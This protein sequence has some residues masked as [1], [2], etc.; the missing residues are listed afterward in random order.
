[1]LAADVLAK[2]ARALMSYVVNTTLGTPVSAP[3]QATVTPVAMTSIFPGAILI[4]GYGAQDQEPVTVSSTTATT[5]TAT[6]ANAHAPSEVVYGPTFPEGYPDKQLFTQAEMLAYATDA[7]NDLLLRT[8]MMVNVA[9]APVEST[10]SLYPMPADAIWLER[11]SVAGYALNEVTQ[12]D[13]DLD[14]PSWRANTASAPQYFWQDGARQLANLGQGQYALSPVPQVGNAA[15]L[16]Y[17]QSFPGPL[18]MTTETLAPD[19]LCYIVKYG[20]L[21]RA[22]IKDGEQCDP[23]RAK[24]CSKRAE[25]GARMVNLFMANAQI[26]IKDIPPFSPLQVRPETVLA[27]EAPLNA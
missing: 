19:M 9:A 21:A 6:F 12:T 25:W 3:G 15:R 16:Y 27:K 20:V 14:S 23:Q 13:L 10:Q 11:I 4:I 5:F 24:Y 26:S 17:S 22:F 2:A 18:T 8:R 1:M 7:Q